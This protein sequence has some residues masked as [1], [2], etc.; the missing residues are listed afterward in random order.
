[1]GQICTTSS[2]CEI[3]DPD[4]FDVTVV[5]DQDVTV[6]P[7]ARLPHVVMICMSGEGTIEDFRRLRLGGNQT[8]HPHKG[9]CQ[10]IVDYISNLENVNFARFLAH[11]AADHPQFPF[12]LPDQED[13]YGRVYE[14]VQKGLGERAAEAFREARNGAED[15]GTGRS[16]NL[17]KI[18]HVFL[19][20]P[21]MVWE[22]LKDEPTVYGCK[23]EC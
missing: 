18:E 23:L 10:D 22:E 5:P 12:A 16:I 8:S 11:C 17:F 20:F 13:E 2:L 1:M 9:T 14:L 19:E 21:G 7:W 4:W 6:S 15:F 3:G